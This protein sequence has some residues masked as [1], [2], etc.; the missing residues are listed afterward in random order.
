MCEYTGIQYFYCTIRML[1][2]L[3]FSKLTIVGADQRCELEFSELGL[4]AELEIHKSLHL[5]SISK[6]VN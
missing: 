6:K 3:V 1:T 4:G 2:F 5:S